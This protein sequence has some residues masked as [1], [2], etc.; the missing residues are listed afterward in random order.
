MISLVCGILKII[1]MNLFKNQ[2]RVTD[3]ENKF[4]VTKEGRKGEKLAVWN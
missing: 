1:Q 2:N 3:I 4:M